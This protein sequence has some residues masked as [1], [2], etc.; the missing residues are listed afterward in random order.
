MSALIVLAA[1]GT[2]GH[3]FPAEAL[4]GE[5]LTRG[6]KVALVT[7]RRGEAFGDRLPGVSLHRIRAGRPGAGLISKMIAAAGIALGTLAA[8]KLLRA[9]APAATVGFGGYPSVPT[10]L[11]AS[12]L[13]VPTLLHEQNARLGRANRWLAPRVKRIATSFAEVDG[14]PR[15]I[16]TLETGNPVRPAITAQRE[17]PYAAPGAGPIRILVT[18]GSQ[19]AAILS[20]VVPA[21]LALLAPALRARI[22]LVQQARPEDVEAVRHLHAARGIAAIVES[23]FTDIPMRLA[24]AHLV[25]ARAGASTVAELC[26]IGRPAILVPYRY[27]ADNHQTANAEALARAGAAWTMREAE[28]TPKVLAEKLIDLVK[29]Q[30]QLTAAA[31]AARKLGAPDAAKRLADLVIATA[32]GAAA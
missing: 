22:E 14:L 6:L 5:L 17:T 1:G 19:G 25:I 30:A 3:I 10:V 9:L 16:A 18:G 11:A 27:A 2:G 8:Q 32:Q 23:F 31:E 12:R 4:A 24:R 20:Q 26:A 29:S 21:A 7:D 13:G 15:G 28:F